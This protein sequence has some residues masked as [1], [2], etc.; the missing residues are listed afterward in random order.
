MKTA[1]ICHEVPCDQ[2]IAER[3]RY[4]AR[5]LITP[6]DLNLEQD[7]F[8]SKLR[9]HNRM[10]HGW[11]VVCGA[12]VCKLPKSK[13]NG[14]KYEPWYVQIQPGY[15]LGPYG[16]E[17]ILDCT[18]KL[19]LRT[20]GV[21]GITGEPC[22]D[23]VDPWC[24][25]VVQEPD[26]GKLYVAVRYKEVQARPVRVQPIGCGCDD[27]K[28]ENSRIVDGYE[29][30][31]LTNCPDSH[32]NPPQTEDLGRG[33]IPACPPCPDEPWV[34]LAEVELDADGNV[35]KID[36]CVCRRLALSFADFWWH[37]SE[38]A[39][40]P[41]P[42]P[43]PEP[44]SPP[45]PSPGPATLVKVDRVETRGVLGAGSRNQVVVFGKNLELVQSMSFGQGVTVEGMKA[46][47]EQLVA[48]LSISA[49]AKP[50]PRT[51]TLIDKDKNKVEVA[52]AVTVEAADA[53]GEP[54]S[55]PTRPDAGP[56]QPAP[57]A[58]DP[59]ADPKG[60]ARPRPTGKRRKRPEDEV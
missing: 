10:L 16:D 57:P 7:Y 60:K 51:M 25:E 30:G 33:P 36:N 24:S 32:Q 8:R 37:C 46:G 20:R 56:A 21:T 52:K 17:I 6:D 45:S 13:N 48:G 40:E 55:R 59:K 58:A 42:A 50:G 2:S 1:T 4:Y 14:T 27:S 41:A 39:K 26:S 43:S 11:G 49:D 3:P 22:V 15:V 12:M 53:S 28:C 44:P 54:G 31:V 38:P 9:W 34:V 18:R 35:V 5:Q 29:I 19:D 47:A 23:A